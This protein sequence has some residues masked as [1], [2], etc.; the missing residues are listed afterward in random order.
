M[1]QS[2]LMWDGAG[3]TI[4]T[5]WI[6]IGLLAGA[7]SWS[8]LSGWP[9]RVGGAV[10][11]IFLL[12]GVFLFVGATAYQLEADRERR[13]FP[14]PGSLV[15]VGGYRIHIYCNGVAD[16]GAPTLIWI[17]G[18]YGAG[19]Y[20]Y[21]LQQSWISGGGRACIIDRAGAGWS[22]PGPSPRSTKQIVVDFERAVA[23]SGENGPFVLVGH[24]L[25]GMVAVNWAS[26]S[27]LDILGVV[28]LD[29]TPQAL[30]ASGGHAR[31][32]GW[33]G[34]PDPSTLMLMSMLGIGTLFPGMHPMNSEE[35]L[36]HNQSLE[37]VRPILKYFE[38]RPRAIAIAMDGFRNSCNGGFE[39]IRSPGALGDLPVLAIVQSF[40]PTAEARRH[41][42]EWSGVQDEQDWQNYIRASEAS[43]DEYPAFSTNGALIL[44]P[45]DF[46]HNFPIENPE[47]TIERIQEFVAALETGQAVS[48]DK[49]DSSAPAGAKHEQQ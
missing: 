4:A 27:A 28:A 35:W 25:G 43:R 24:S 3:W 18:G 6:V 30:I 5:I 33:C 9:A 19:M 23:A 20:S 1:W 21:P 44:L 17:S 29:P 11:A 36:T 2:F 47:Y 14:M 42:E 26:R 7:A 49:I 46:G 48:E 22:D 45:K 41:A 37:N 39:E 31:I 34:A 13:S 40:E 38:S 15:D 32:N 16:A 10:S 12:L 8:R